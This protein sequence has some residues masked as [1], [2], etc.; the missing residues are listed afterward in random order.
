MEPESNKILIVDDNPIMARWVARVVQQLN[1]SAV[2][3]AHGA[4][5]LH[6]LANDR[7][8]AVLSD[9][10]MPMMNGFELLQTIQSIYP[11]LPVILMTADF[12]APYL[13]AAR[14]GGALALLEKPVT[15]TQLIRLLH[16]GEDSESLDSVE[17]LHLLAPLEVPQ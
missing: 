2:L 6:Y 11:G 10:E 4:E 3:A 7:F 17:G 8:A 1:Y 13:E 5:A 16:D 15:P 12:N 14:A 9:V